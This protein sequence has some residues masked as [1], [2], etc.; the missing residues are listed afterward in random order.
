MVLGGVPEHFQVSAGRW[1]EGWQ[2]RIPWNT[3][4]FWETNNFNINRSCWEPKLLVITC[5]KAI[6][7]CNKRNMLYGRY[8]RCTIGNNIIRFNHIGVLAHIIL[9]LKKTI[10]QKE[11]EGGGCCLPFQSTRLLLYEYLVYSLLSWLRSGMYLT[12][13]YAW[14]YICHIK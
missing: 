11:M 7:L 10:Y 2:H 4:T 14:V 3:S 8:V 6:I 1:G 9:V 12:S 13:C 5:S